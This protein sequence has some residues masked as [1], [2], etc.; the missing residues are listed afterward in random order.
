MK[1]EVRPDWSS[2]SKKMCAFFIVALGWCE[3]NDTGY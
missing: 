1:E 3:I 2:A